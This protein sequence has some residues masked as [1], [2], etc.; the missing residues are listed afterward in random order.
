[1]KEKNIDVRYKDVKEW[2]EKQELI[3][4]IKPFKERKKC[5]P[6]ITLNHNKFLCIDSMFITDDLLAVKVAIDLFSKK[7]YAK[8]KKI[9]RPKGNDRGT[10]IKSTDTRNFLSQI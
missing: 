7:V 6:I 4:R 5:N 9:K 10:S 2:Y 1:M 8:V 3:Q